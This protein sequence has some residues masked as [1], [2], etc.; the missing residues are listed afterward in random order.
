MLTAF[1]LFWAYFHQGGSLASPTGCCG[2][3]SQS[4]IFINVLDNAHL[5]IQI[6]T[7]LV[8]FYTRKEFHSKFNTEPFLFFS[9]IF[10]FISSVFISGLYLQVHCPGSLSSPTLK[11]K[12]LH[13]P[14]FFLHTWFTDLYCFLC[15]LLSAKVRRVRTNSHSVLC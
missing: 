10:T 12:K 14:I 9:K 6:L 5:Y 11:T 8:L 7:A 1:W 3:C 15:L 13:L 2:G 4:T